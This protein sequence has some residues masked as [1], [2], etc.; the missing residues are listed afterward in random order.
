MKAFLILLIFCAP[1]FAQKNDLSVFAVGNFNGGSFIYLSD[2]TP[3]A[4]AYKSSAG[5]GVEYRRWLTPN[6]AV[7]TWFMANPSEGKQFTSS[8]QPYLYNFPLIRYEFGLPVTLRFWG[9]KKLNPFMQVGFGFVVTQ[10]L[11]AISLAGC[12]EDFNMI[13]GG[14]FDYEISSRWTARVGFLAWDGTQGCYNDPTCHSSMG[15][16]QDLRLGIGYRW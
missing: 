3:V 16:A 15:Q 5:G 2:G 9:K 11:E 6:V 13:A 14:G 8:T 4:V 7:G 10:S 1:L 12:S